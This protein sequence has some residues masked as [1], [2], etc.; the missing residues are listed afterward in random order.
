MQLRTNLWPLP[1]VSQSRNREYQIIPNPCQINPKPMP[2]HTQPMPNQP[3]SCQIL[4]DPNQ[5]IPTH[6]AYITNVMFPHILHLPG[7]STL[8]KADPHQRSSFPVVPISLLKVTTTWPPVGNRITKFPI[9]PFGIFC[10]HGLLKGIAIS[11]VSGH[12]LGERCALTLLWQYRFT[13]V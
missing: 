3:K 13:K 5:I 2:N 1:R 8:T 10:A 11:I 12:P 7:S 9:G 6:D 4:T